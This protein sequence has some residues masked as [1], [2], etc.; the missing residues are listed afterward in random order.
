MEGGGGGERTVTD[1]KQ[2]FK[3]PSVGGGG[4]RMQGPPPESLQNRAREPDISA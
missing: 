1:I 3:S 4:D 2:T